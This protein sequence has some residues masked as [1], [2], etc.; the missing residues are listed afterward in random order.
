MTEKTPE[1]ETPQEQTSDGS[2]YAHGS[3]QDE[4]TAA[5]SGKA[6]TTETDEK[7]PDDQAAFQTDTDA[8]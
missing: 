6:A 5:P 1:D 2:D 4:E 8:D 3:E 7:L